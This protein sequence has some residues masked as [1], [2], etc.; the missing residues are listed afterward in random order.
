MTTSG[1]LSFLC[2]G[3]MIASLV[4]CSSVETARHIAP[5]V[6]PAA[7]ANSVRIGAYTV[8][9]P[10][11]SGSVA[12]RAAVSSTPIRTEAVTPPARAS[13]PVA[14]LKPG[15]DLHLEMVSEPALS[16]TLQIDS[17]GRVA[18]P[19]AGPLVV[20]GLSVSQAERAVRA[21]Y[22]AGYFVNPELHLSRSPASSRR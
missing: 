20:A 16:T 13:R 5:P 15:E 11:P 10:L 12:G 8:Y 19:L 4:A 1:W 6:V 7:S 17:R 9:A 2:C 14:A 21:A 18:L 3:M 22:A